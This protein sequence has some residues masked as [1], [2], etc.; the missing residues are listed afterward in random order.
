M[1]KIFYDHLIILEEV[2]GVVDK[3]AKTQE[4]KEELWAI[5]DEMIHHRILGCILDVLPKE[6]HHEFL[7]K[8]HSAPH[9]QGLIDFLN[10]VVEEDVEELIRNESK[11]LEQ[12]ILKEVK[13]LK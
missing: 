10:S 7:E 3:T 9:D 12:E 8:F 4:E 6:H 1:S 11:G 5:V 13:F 2:E